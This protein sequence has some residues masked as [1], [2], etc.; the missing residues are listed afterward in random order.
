MPFLNAKDVGPVV[1]ESPPADEGVINGAIMDAWQVP[2]EDVGPAGVDEG[3]GGKYLVLPPGCKDTVPDGY[4]ALPSDT[5]AGYSL[6][7]PSSRATARTMSPRPPVAGRRHYF[8]FNSGGIRT[9][10]SSPG[11]SS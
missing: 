4:I 11:G 5:H 1:L 8:E 7:R 9:H 6:L 10:G 3:K 2:L